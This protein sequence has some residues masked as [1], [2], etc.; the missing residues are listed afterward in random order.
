MAGPNVNIDSWDNIIKPHLEDICSEPTEFD[1]HD[2][3]QS[4]SP[5][6]SLQR[7][8]Y[9]ECCDKLEEMKKLYEGAKKYHQRG[10]MGRNNIDMILGDIERMQQENNCS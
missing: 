9:N 1:F 6:L 2:I 3:F 8:L 10:T 4:P 7:T 5:H